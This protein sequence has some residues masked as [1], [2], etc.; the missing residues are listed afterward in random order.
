[1]GHPKERLKILQNY[2]PNIYIYIDKYYILDACHQAKQRK[3]CFFPSNTQTAH[4]FE[5]LHID[6]WRSFSA[7]S[8]FGF[9]YFLTIVDDFTR[10]NWLFPMHNISKVR[11]SV[12]NFVT[13]AGNDFLCMISFSKCII[14]Q[15]T[16]VETPEQNDIVERKHQHLLNVTQTLIF[17]FKLPTIF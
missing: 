3:L 10:Y 6:I 2:Y 16:C 13:Y 15:I 7:V 5:L 8:M 11:I 4:A 9:K 14:H 1:M 17:Q 12:I